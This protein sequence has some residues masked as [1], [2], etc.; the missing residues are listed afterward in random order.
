MEDLFFI[1][2]FPD[3][4]RVWIYQGSK[5]FT[6]N[7][8][9]E[10][11]HL[12]NNFVSNWKAHNNPLKAIAQVVKNRFIVIAVDE[13]QAEI[14]GCGIDTSVRFIKELENK[15]STTFFDRMLVCYQTENGTIQTFNFH[16]LFSLLNKGT[17]TLDTLIYNNL[18][19]TV[20]E[21]KE[22]WLVPL[23][24]SWMAPF[25]KAGV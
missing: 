10:I 11:N 5:E 23:N 6:P 9:N 17:L 20:K 2:N 8:T 1:K 19:S 22:N 18:V 4:A 7:E 12:L 24:Q 21:L 25:I 3:N 14:S 15:Y 16:H 13:T